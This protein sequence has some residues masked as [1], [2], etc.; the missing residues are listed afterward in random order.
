MPLSHKIYCLGL[1]KTGTTSLDQA[2]QS[3]GLA[4]IGFNGPALRQ[5]LRFGFEQRHRDLLARG[6][7]FSDWPWCLMWRHV[8]EEDSWPMK[9]ILT[10]RQSPQAWLR[11][12][13]RHAMETPTMAL[14]QS[15]YQIAMP[16]GY[17]TQLQDHY[18]RHSEAVQE[19]F[20]R[21]GRTKDLL[22]VQIEQ[23]DALAK[24]GEFVGIEFDQPGLPHTNQSG[25]R[26]V[27]AKLLLNNLSAANRNRR[28]FGKSAI[29][30]EE[31]LL[32]FD[33]TLRRPVLADKAIGLHVQASLALCDVPRKN[34]N[35]FRRARQKIIRNYVE[36]CFEL[37][38]KHKLYGT[39]RSAT[40]QHASGY[41]YAGRDHVLADL[42]RTTTRLSRSSAILPNLLVPRKFS[43]KLLIYKAFGQMSL[44]G[45][46]N[47]LQDP[48]L[49]GDEAT[50]LLGQFERPFISDKPQIPD[51]DAIAPGAY[52]FKA[53]YGWNLHRPIAFPITEEQRA[54]LL[55]DAKAWLSP[56]Q[57]NPNPS[58]WK[59]LTQKQVF[60][61]RDLG[62]GSHAV[63]DWKFFA[64]RGRIGLVQVDQDRSENHRQTVY[65]AAFN[66][67]D[68]PLY[69]TKGTPVARPKNFDVMCEIVRTLGAQFEFMRIDLYNVDGAIYLG[70]L[71]V[72]PNDA[73]RP[74]LC[75]DL[76]IRLGKIWEE[77]GFLDGNHLLGAPNSDQNS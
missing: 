64:F 4:V 23:A 32:K 13:K 7:S 11:S 16:H 9:Y 8:F 51:N 59:S 33:D 43:E 45:T 47:K 72:V 75:R 52:F 1:P 35:Q 41:Q 71:S 62:L 34:P 36:K 28:G 39:D 63:D 24:I 42:I 37:I 66:F 3:A 60:L 27:P 70:E 57:T 50:A 58:W 61:E 20:E 29:T 25:D 44:L 40:D 65:D 15:V 76:D 38:E 67:I 68:Q 73:A 54:T 10:E 74:L 21:A 49:I 19:C 2:F 26:K 6:D 56:K 5:Y 17:E 48:A 69:F 18:Q 30:I 14:R 77:E 31:S 22:V 55:A 12:M 53:N 46:E